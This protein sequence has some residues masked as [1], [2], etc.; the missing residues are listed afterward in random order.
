MAQAPNAL[1]LLRREHKQ[2]QSMLHRFEKTDGDDAQ[3]ELCEQIVSGLKT[4]TEIEEEVFYPFLRE[5]TA[6]E[7]LFQEATIEHGLVSD[8][9]EQLPK[10]PPG[11][12]RIKAM[13]QVLA[14]QVRR[15][16]EEE[17]QAIFPQIEKTGVDL[18]ALG[19]ALEECRNGRPIGDAADRGNGHA[20]HDA[21]H[22]KARKAEHR[23]SDK[24]GHPRAE[25][26]ADR[27]EADHKADH[28]ADQKADR[29]DQ[30]EHRE[31]HEKAQQGAQAADDRRFLD[32]HRDGLSRSTQHAKWIHQPGEGA[33]RDGQTLATRSMEVI[34]AWAEARGGHPATT[35]GGDAEHPRVLRI[36]FPDYDKDLLPVSW[37]AWGGT[38]EDRDLV[39]LFQEKMSDGK[40]SNFFRLDSP[41]RE[42][43]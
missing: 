24:A 9:L 14:E 22:D 26:K 2:L 27:H 34:Q 10:E 13:V 28:K 5:A 43:A 25:R 6:R 40:Q 29:H 23:S 20:K 36:D 19:E 4:H 30:H 32:A 1:D 15:H 16:V 35:P 21:S 3:R 18:K 8:L 7:D 31:H 33:D 42:D 12:P 41:K 11:T 37:E 38:F 39:F 17:E